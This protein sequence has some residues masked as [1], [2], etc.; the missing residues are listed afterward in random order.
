MQFIDKA[1][2]TVLN[3]LAGEAMAAQEKKVEKRTI[4]EQK[5]AGQNNRLQLV[6]VEDIPLK[7]PV[8]SRR[9]GRAVTTMD[10]IIC[11]YVPRG[12]NYHLN[13]DGTRKGKGFQG[14]QQPQA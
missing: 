10:N 7:R 13:A 1:L 2:K 12:K 4:L 8:H 5:I 6:R 14:D 9:L 3:T 11:T